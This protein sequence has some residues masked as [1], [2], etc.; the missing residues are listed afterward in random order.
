MKG[1]RDLS[2]SVY[3]DPIRILLVRPKKRNCLFPVTV[4]KKR[5]G[6]SVKNKICII[7]LVQNVFYACFTLIVSWE[8]GKNFGVGI[9]LIKTC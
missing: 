8:G 2:K 9:F 1:E 6:R 4:R 7:F 3:Q 5:V